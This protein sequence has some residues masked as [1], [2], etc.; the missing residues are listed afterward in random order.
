MADAGGPAW[1]H[2]GFTRLNDHV[3]AGLYETAD[4]AVTQVERVLAIAHRIDVQLK[5]TASPALVPALSDIRGQLSALVYPGFVTATGFD[6]MAHLYRYLG[7]I[8]HRLDRLPD[9]PGRDRDLMR[10]AQTLQADYDRLRDRPPGED[11]DPQLEQI[12]WMLEE[13]R[14]SLF[15]QQLGTAYPVSE[16]RIRKAMAT[17]TPDR[18]A[19]PSAS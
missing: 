8:E 15:A 13:L 6:R 3:R 14:V 2:E 9:N 16:K 7:A 19:A 11:P 5:S 18:S 17:V 10:Q 12:R 4:A 1:D